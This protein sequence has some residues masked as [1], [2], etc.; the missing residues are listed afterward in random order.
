MFKRLSDDLI[1]LMF[2]IFYVSGINYINYKPVDAPD[3]KSDEKA[4]KC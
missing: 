2:L 4:I 1:L 3:N